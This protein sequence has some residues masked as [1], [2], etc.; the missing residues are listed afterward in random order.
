MSKIGSWD[1]EFTPD[2]EISKVTGA[3][4]V[5]VK[6]NVYH[7]SN[8]GSV[9]YKD[10]DVI[11]IHFESKSKIAAPK[12]KNVI[13]N[14]YEKSQKTSDIT[15]ATSNNTKNDIGMPDG[16]GSAG[17][18]YRQDNTEIRKPEEH[19]NPEKPQKSL[20]ETEEDY[21]KDTDGDG[22]PDYYEDAIGTNK[23]DPDTDHD[24]L[25]DTYELLCTETDPT[26]A[27]T[28]GNGKKDGDEDPD[29]DGLSNKQECAYKTDP[30]SND[31][32]MDG[33]TDGQEINSHT[34]PLKADTDGDSITDADELKLGLDPNNPATNGTP[35]SKRIFS[36]TADPDST[37]F[38]RINDGKSPFKVSVDV[39]AAGVVS[40]NLT[41]ME[42]GY[43]YTI[44]NPSII[45]KVPEFQYKN[46]LSVEEV[47]VKFKLDSS[48]TSNTLGVFEG[49]EFK[50]IKRLNI[51]MFDED[52]NMLLPVETFHD[53]SSNTVYTKTDRMG[54]YC[55][56]DMELFLQNLGIEPDKKTAE[57]LN[58]I[59]KIN[60]DSPNTFEKLAAIN[61]NSGKTY[62]DNF[63]VAFI[64]D[65]RVSKEE[66][67][68]QKKN[69][70][71]ISRTVFKLSPHARI[72]I[73]TQN[74]NAKTTCKPLI[75]NGNRFFENYNDLKT[76]LDTLS[77]SG[78]TKNHVI[79]SDGIKAAAENCDTSRDTYVFSIFDQKNV[80]YN[81]QNGREALRRAVS[82]NCNISIISKIDEGYK[83]GYAHEM[84][85]LANGKVFGNPS[86]FSQDVLDY[87]YGEHIAKEDMGE[88]YQIISA[89]GLTT[90]KLDAPITKEYRELSKLSNIDHSQPDTDG[91][92]LPDYKEIDF[93]AKSPSGNLLIDFANNDIIL[94]KY[95]DVILSSDKPFI[96][97]S[98][99][100]YKTGIT[101]TEDFAEL[102]STRV[103]PIISD[104]TS[105]DGDNDN[106]EDIV[107]YKY[108][109][110]CLKYDQFS[111]LYG[112]YS[113]NNT[114]IISLKKRF[115]EAQRIMDSESIVYSMMWDYELYTDCID[116]DT[117]S[118]E[119][120]FWV[121]LCRCFN[122]SV[123]KAFPA[124]K[125]ETF[126]ADYVNDDENPPIPCIPK[127]V[128]Y[129]R[130]NLNR[131]P[132]SLYE[133]L[134]SNEER[135][136]WELLLVKDSVFHMYG[137]NGEYNLKLVTPMKLYGGDVIF[138]AVYD[139]K[140]DLLDVYNDPV[141]CGTYNFASPKDEIEHLMYDLYTYY[142][143]GN[144]SY[145]YNE[146]K[147]AL[148]GLKTNL[149]WILLGAM[150]NIPILS[151]TIEN[152]EFGNMKEKV[153]ILL[154][155]EN[156]YKYVKTLYGYADV[157]N[158]VSETFVDNT[159]SQSVT[160]SKTYLKS[161]WKYVYE[162]INR[163]DD[164]IFD[165]ISYQVLFGDGK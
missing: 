89:T 140:G 43:S 99:N 139:I 29:K 14:A 54:T 57:E 53:T 35:D 76:K 123:K 133:L 68:A 75:Y 49:E 58:S 72:Y 32:D 44:A 51:F 137:E 132:K 128:H 131:A 36:Q 102:K 141:N 31:T 37:I 98:L 34:D 1:L 84:H 79:L 61:D 126:F 64:L 6:K 165:I 24:G 130:N 104:P 109:K 101:D 38:S 47:T 13:F 56:I 108:S 116:S 94:P 59:T 30:N 119:I 91:D 152:I 121:E 16:S 67:D 71:E 46:G 12:I 4:S 92:G 22:L 66:F 105:D 87:I 25:T 80:V 93:E 95:F 7:F 26:K 97:D 120:N 62:K 60:A 52:I 39:K 96:Q 146:F 103:L 23:N 41:V 114:D 149:Q 144:V 65:T 106:V 77:R 156:R 147:W 50:G 158:I 124:P 159:S 5:S 86:D 18:P 161:R 151:D 81:S 21:T 9:S 115:E 122:K 160:I 69:V 83:Y 20:D 125:K 143:Y 118:V 134:N 73:F 112:M 10:T 8:K 145:V 155:W 82:S 88:E 164:R 157:Y 107:E 136:K 111:L 17:H 70:L 15:P 11:R 110:S 55:L 148:K 100:R 45:G 129:F 63:N 117:N 27:D 154:A 78:S 142:Y 40:N 153:L 138:E 113:K 2:F 33:L 135:K 74:K 42:S 162:Q 3:K 163:P 19:E 127:E 85:E 150:T 28:N 48:I 90:I